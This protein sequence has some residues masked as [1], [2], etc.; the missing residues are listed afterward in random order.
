M[1]VIKIKDNG[2]LTMWGFQEIDENSL[3]EVLT[4][5]EHEADGI[6]KAFTDI[7]EKVYKEKIA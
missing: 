7:G 2:I 4:F 5:K 6:V 3:K 1:Y